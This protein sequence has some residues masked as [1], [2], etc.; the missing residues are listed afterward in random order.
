MAIAFTQLTP[1]ML[2]DLSFTS[3]LERAHTF[4]SMFFVSPFRLFPLAPEKKNTGG[5]EASV[6]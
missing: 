6:N 4:L 2:V 1:F 5:G 3:F